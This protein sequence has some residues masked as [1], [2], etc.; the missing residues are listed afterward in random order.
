MKRYTL[1][2]KLW[3]ALEKRD[4][5]RGMVMNA[6]DKLESACIEVAEASMEI[7]LFDIRARDKSD[8]VK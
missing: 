4:A 5:A 7:R 1:E 8:G 6:N 3:K 2:K